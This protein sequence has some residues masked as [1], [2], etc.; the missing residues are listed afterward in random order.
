M[1]YENSN[2]KFCMA[3]EYFVDPN[4][5]EPIQLGTKQF[6]FKDLIWPIKLIFHQKDEDEEYRIF[7]HVGSQHYINSKLEPILIF[8]TKNLTIM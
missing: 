4:S 3:N 6:P 1:K 8:E 2:F 5:V 7:L